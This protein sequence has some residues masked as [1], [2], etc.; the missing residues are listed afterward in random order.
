VLLVHG[1]CSSSNPFVGSG[2]S[3][4][5]AHVFEDF[6][7]NLPNDAFA[8]RLDEFA[9]SKGLRGFSGI[10]HSQ[11]GIALVHLRSTYW[12]GLDV[13][14]LRFDADTCVDCSLLL[15]LAARVF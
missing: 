3:W 15:S 10:G 11:G 2:H 1:Y 6:N 5:A 9:V 4:R 14:Q 13:Q 12:S 7:Q 8:Q